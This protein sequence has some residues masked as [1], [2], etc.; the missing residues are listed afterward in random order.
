MSTRYLRTS[1]GQAEIQARALAL[2]RPVRNLLLLLNPDQTGAHWVE[3]V[4]GCT[5]DDL[6]LLESH[7]LIAPPPAVPEPAAVPLPVPAKTA[8]VADSGIDLSAL[9]TR[10]RGM[11]YAP[12]YEALNSHGKETLGL[13]GGYRFALEI[14]RCSGPADLQDLALRY[15]AQLRDKHGMD[16]IRSFVARL[17]R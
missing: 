5:L 16:A 10:L 3:Q 2:P 6:A 4:K 12:L 15:L 7:G 11:P 13:V 9:Q 17:P 8:P 1:A 14:E